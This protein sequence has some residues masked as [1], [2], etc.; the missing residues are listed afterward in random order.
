MLKR[1][2]E[3]RS[4]LLLFFSSS[5]PNFHQVYFPVPWLKISENNSH[6]LVSESEAMSKKGFFSTLNLETIVLSLLSWMI[7]PFFFSFCLFLCFLVFTCFACDF[8]VPPTK[9]ACIS[10][11]LI[12]GL[13]DF[14][15]DPMIYFGML[16]NVI[17]TEASRLYR[18]VCAFAFCHC[19]RNLPFWVAVSSILVSRMKTVSRDLRWSDQIPWLELLT[20]IILHQLT[21]R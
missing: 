20:E 6:W 14:V 19:H 8:A 15:C 13:W 1:T 21:S 9:G 4:V 12:L 2:P 7:V 10:P 3:L 18:G 11:P 17:Q 16:A 5:C